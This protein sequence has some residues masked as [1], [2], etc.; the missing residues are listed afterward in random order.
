MKAVHIL[1]LARSVLLDAGSLSFPFPFH[2]SFWREVMVYLSNEAR[3]SKLQQRWNCLPHVC[4]A[5]R[6]QEEK[7]PPRLVQIRSYTH[8]HWNRSSWASAAAVTCYQDVL[9]LALAGGH[10]GLKW[11]HLVSLL[12]LITV[13][14]TFGFC[15][16]DTYAL[17][18]VIYCGLLLF[19]GFFQWNMSLP[20]HCAANWPTLHI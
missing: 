14:S 3:C 11:G 20:A 2:F 18:S 10:S 5:S 7:T 17:S 13:I 15:V 6:S 4:T 12:Q 1:C 19:L 9:T 8:L 16:K